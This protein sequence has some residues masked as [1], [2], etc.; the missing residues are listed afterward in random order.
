MALTNSALINTIGLRLQQ[1]A[2]AFMFQ[3]MEE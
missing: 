2:K 1:A 3:T